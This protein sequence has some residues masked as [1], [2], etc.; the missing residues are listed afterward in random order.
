DLESDGI[1]QYEFDQF[2]VNLLNEVLENTI[3]RYIKLDVIQNTEA[4]CKKESKE[5]CKKHY[6]NGD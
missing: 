3:S 2:P 1:V 6:S 4:I 5:W